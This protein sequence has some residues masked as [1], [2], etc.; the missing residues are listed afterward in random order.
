MN[1]NNSLNKTEEHALPE[2][3]IHESWRALSD[4]AGDQWLELERVWMIDDKELYGL[5]ADLINALKA[6][7]TVFLPIKTTLWMKLL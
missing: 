2:F 3:Q 4:H 7:S 6:K 5:I 1:L